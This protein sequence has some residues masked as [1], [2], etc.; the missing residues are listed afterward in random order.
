MATAEAITTASAR[1]KFVDIDEQTYTMDPALIERAIGPANQGDY[2]CSP[3]WPVR[4][5]GSHP[6]R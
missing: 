1:P 4:G 3:L 2:A 6:G 5:H